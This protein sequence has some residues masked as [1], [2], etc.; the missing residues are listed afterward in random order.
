MKAKHTPGP[1]A[2]VGRWVEHVS[3]KRADICNCD[4]AS[5][6]QDGRSDAEICANARLIAA[7]PELLAELRFAVSLLKPMLGHTAQVQ[8]MEA[9][10][11]KSTGSAS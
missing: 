5:M 1:W 3:D 9:V 10:I 8:R 4:P 11:A 6:G 7:A 2:A